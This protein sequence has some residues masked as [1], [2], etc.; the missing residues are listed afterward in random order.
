[1]D[2]CCELGIVLI[3]EMSTGNKTVVIKLPKKAKLP[4]R[5]NLFKPHKSSQFLTRSDA[6]SLGEKHQSAVPLNSL[7]SLN[8]R[9]SDI[10]LKIFKD[11]Q[12]GR[13]ERL[14]SERVSRMKHSPF[15]F[16]RGLPALMLYDLAWSNQTGLIQ[17]I[18]GDAHLMNFRGFASQERTLLF[19]VNDFDETLIAPFEWDIKRLATS[20]CIAMEGLGG[21]DLQSQEAVYAMISDYVDYFDQ[22]KDLGPIEQHYRFFR[23]RDFLNNVS[24]PEVLK[25]KIALARK[26]LK[27]D[28]QSLVPRI[29]KPDSSGGNKFFDDGSGMWRPEVGEPF[30]GDQS[31]F[32]K[33]YRQSLSFE[34]KKI[35]DRY[36]LSDVIMRVV[37]VGSVG[38][39]TAI[40]LFEDPN[41]EDPLIL[42]MKEAEP[43]LLE[44]LYSR[45]IKHQ[46][47]RVVIGKKWLQSSS[48]IFLGWATDPKDK[49]PYYVRQLRN[50]KI[51]AD[52][53]KMTIPFLTEYSKNAGTAL[54]DAHVR[55]GNASILFG[56]IKNKDLFAETV[57]QFANAYAKRNEKDYSYFCKAIQ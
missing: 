8:T 55:S 40:A 41:Q 13:L 30:Y 57:Y 53:E 15:R 22:S 6:I 44:G 14:N 49:R 56:Y 19:G 51:K 32:F 23:G 11:S 18:C 42:Q 54:A 46:G 24:D 2:C 33:N 39:R 28:A 26:Q 50:M 29:S 34:I 38:T 31:A 20:I 12:I 16:F 47:K 3:R 45:A 52:E 37:G 27:K 10:V 5:I 9:D 35:F 48:D 7:N 4:I 17:Q 21:S 25:Q 43:P 1:M 36:R